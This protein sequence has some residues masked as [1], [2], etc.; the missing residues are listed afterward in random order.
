[1][2]VLAVSPGSV[3]TAMLK[4]TSFA[5]EMTVDD[6]AKVI[7]WC[8]GEAPDAMTGTNVEVFG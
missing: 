4:G 8:C 6:V 1:M 2:Q 3:D 5:P 7:V